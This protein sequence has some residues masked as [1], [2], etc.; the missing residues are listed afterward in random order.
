MDLYRYYI[1]NKSID[2]NSN[3]FECIDD[4]NEVCTCTNA[5]LTK[6]VNKY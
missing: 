5:L 3:N 1:Y 4:A 6:T 2:L